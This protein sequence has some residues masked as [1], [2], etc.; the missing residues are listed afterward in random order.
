MNNFSNTKERIKL[1]RDG[2]EQTLSELVCEN[3][4]LVKSIASRFL[5]R[6][7]DFD[8]L[9]QIGMIGLVKAIRG[10]DFSYDTALTTYAVPL[11][12]GEIKRFLRDDGII[13]VNRETK[14]NA[15]HIMRFVEDYEKINGSSPSV[16]IVG[17][18]LG[19]GEEEVVFALNSAQ[20]IS[21]LVTEGDNGDEFELPIGIDDTDNNIEKL[22]VREAVERLSEED[23]KLV[24]LR[25]FRDM[26]QVQ[27]AKILGITQVK[28]SRR[29]KKICQILKT[30]LE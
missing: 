23:R 16:S 17:S 21:A 13:K 1:A 20:P 4:P 11:I 2:D 28:V 8:D 25:F 22:A 15:M 29:E 9:V 10:F 26:T 24:E 6:G 27:T 12:Y 19:L 7:A 30:L 3:T 14:T 18:A 5:D